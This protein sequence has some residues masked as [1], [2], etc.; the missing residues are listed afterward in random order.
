MEKAIKFAQRDVTITPEE[1]DIFMSAKNTLVFNKNM[2][3]Q[4]TDADDLFDVTMGSYDGTETC[5]LGGTYILSATNNIIPKENIGL[6]RDDGLAIVHMTPQEKE[7]VKKQ[8]CKKLFNLDYKLQ[9]M[10]ILP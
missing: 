8:L 5:E 4:K 7:N 3:W 2:P 9:P 1:I 6:Y 10:L